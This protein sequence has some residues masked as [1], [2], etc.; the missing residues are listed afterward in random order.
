MMKSIFLRTKIATLISSLLLT[1][2]G[3][4]QDASYPDWS[5]AKAAGAI[6]R[7]WIPDW[8]PRSSHTIK[9]AHDLDTNASIL[10]L[11]FS[12]AENWQVPEVCEPVEGELAV[13]TLQ[14]SWWPPQL[15]QQP[16]R[17]FSFYDCRDWEATNL[18]LKTGYLAIRGQTLY[19]WRP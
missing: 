9:E 12:E 16:T 15:S 4:I 17:E 2:C 8:L 11:T 7:G 14:R 1:A 6:T 18:G 10:T 5:A 19:F 3:E 13:P